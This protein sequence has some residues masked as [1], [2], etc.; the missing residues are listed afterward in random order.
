MSSTGSGQKVINRENNQR[1]RQVK[2]A[3]WI[4]QSPHDMNRD[5]GMGVGGYS[6]NNIDML[7]F[8]TRK[9]SSGEQFKFRDIMRSSHN[10]DS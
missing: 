2:E 10:D 1:L 9:Q 3:I 7:L 5:L 8:T 4:S 6:L